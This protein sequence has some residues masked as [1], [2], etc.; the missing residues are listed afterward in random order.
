MKHAVSISI[1]SS[2]RNKTV[3]IDILGEKVQLERIGTDGNLQEAARLY[4]EMDGKVD[5]FGV[6]GTILGFLISNRWYPLHSLQSLFAGVKQTPLVDGTGLKETLELKAADN[7]DR[8][9]GDQVGIKR[10]F[11]T[12]AVDRFG[13][14][15]G[16]Y[17][18]GYECII[19]DLMFALGLSLPIRK[20]KTLIKVAKVLLP[21][22]TRLPFEWLYPVGEAQEKR[23]PRFQKYF[24]WATVINGDCH[25]ITRYMPDR[26]DGKIIVTNTTTADDRELFRHSGVKYLMTTTP[27]LEGRTFGTNM[28]EAALV[29]AAGIRRQIDYARDKDYY[30]F[31]NES[32]DKLGMTPHIQEL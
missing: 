29:A 13:L 8:E 3:Q 19:G 12:S 9:L 11:M 5:A 24:E 1:G 28:M 7:L 23:T 4:R 20:E 18:A 26:L 6:G 10:A 25:Y 17:R 30:R 16:F 32:L 15:H 31:I 2:K 14:S 21:V 27:M 22:M